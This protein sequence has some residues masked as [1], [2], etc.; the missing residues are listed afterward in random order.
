MNWQNIAQM[1]AEFGERPMVVFDASLDARYVSRRFLQLLGR[2]GVTVPLPW[3]ALLGTSPDDAR[4]RSCLERAL[5]GTATRCDIIARREDGRNV[6]LLL[7]C[8]P[9]PEAGRAVVTSVLAASPTVFPDSPVLEGPIDYE[10]ALGQGRFGSLV[11]LSGPNL[12][13]ADSAVGQKCFRVLFGR[14]GPCD[15]CPALA[16]GASA[17]SAVSVLSPAPEGPFYVLSA[18]RQSTER[19]RLR[20]VSVS[21]STLSALVQAKIVRLARRAQLSPRERDV[22]ELLVLGRSFKE[23]GD[24]LGIRER[25]VKFHQSNLLEKLGADGRSDLVRL[26]L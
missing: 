13:S 2:Q 18:E 17:P 21:E 14:D 23:I 3:H 25:T 9:S 11:S 15:G 6:G 5:E 22:L 7:A 24:I 12:P 8:A 1:L 4:T 16:L 20:A 26:I 10:I 19:V